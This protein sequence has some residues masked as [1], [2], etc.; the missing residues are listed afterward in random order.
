[1]ARIIMHIDVNNAFLSWS[2]VL[3]LKQGLGYDI[4]RQYSIIG[5]EDDK[6]RG[7]VLA[8]STPIKKK[9]VVTGESIYLARRKCPDL[10][11][12]K[13]NYKWYKKMSDAF[14]SLIYEYTPDVEKMSIDECFIDYSP[15][16]NVYGDEVE[17]AYML[18]NRIKKELGFTVNVGIGNNK[19]CA[20]MASDFQKPDRVHTLFE[21]EVAS[22]MQVLPIEKL[23][24][25]GKKTANKL[26]NLNINTIYDLSIQSVSTLY[27]YFKNKA[28][29]MIES[30]N[31]IGSD[32][33]DSS[34]RNP[35]EL[36]NSITLPC[37]LI[38]K[39]D[40]WDILNSIAL[41]LA[42]QLRRDGKFAF[43]V[44]VQLKNS[45]F[46]NYTHQVKLDNPT[47]S[48][49]IIFDVAKKLVDEMWRDDEIRLVGLGVFDLTR[50]FNYQPSLFDDF[51]I[52][53][54]SVLDDTLDKIKEKYGS[55]SIK[56][57]SMS[58]KK[59]VGK[60]YL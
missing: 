24:F 60:K 16:K 34:A 29:S 51:D 39:E 10:K 46:K 55:D 3:F 35:K 42:V 38:H 21:D 53:K 49:K 48:S 19:L 56:K 50:E 58:G 31:G 43:G 15:I 14:F 11:V 22:K 27:P 37:N 32:V 4:R 40:V 26:R 2:A 12:Y 20:K 25:I 17:F 8:K 54:D 23:F 7:I 52:A 44:R 45:N 13:P 5:Y 59:M 36:S 30:A 41:N 28:I 1:M 18:K 6:R 57:A 9:G 33:V 47:D